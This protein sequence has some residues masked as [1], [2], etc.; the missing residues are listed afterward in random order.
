MQK[1][2]L[3]NL[4]E[5]EKLDSLCEPAKHVNQWRYRS[6]NGRSFNCEFWFNGGSLSG[7]GL[8]EQFN[9]V[10]IWV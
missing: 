3:L 9:Q 1:K 4:L 2:I 10:V 5:E 6:V 8:L 7:D